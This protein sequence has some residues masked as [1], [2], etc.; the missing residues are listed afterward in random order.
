[1]QSYLKP[2]PKASL[3]SKKH[4]P[5]GFVTVRFV[6]E[7]R[8]CNVAKAC[9]PG[10]SLPAGLPTRTRGYLI[11]WPMGA[12]LLAISRRLVAIWL[13]AIWLY[14]LRVWWPKLFGDVA[15]LAILEV[16]MCR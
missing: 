9:L 12:R 1:M 10:R 4:F 5:L 3:E 15:Y 16:A 11:S 7:E 14:G 2:K 13:L 6:C 8:T